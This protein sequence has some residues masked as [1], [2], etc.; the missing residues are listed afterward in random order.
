MDSYKAP[1]ENTSILNRVYTLDFIKNNKALKK[2]H[3]K[4]ELDVYGSSMEGF[5]V[6]YIW[7][8]LTIYTKTL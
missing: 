6:F 8:T 5:G 3:E 4:H 7:R 2:H 1:Q